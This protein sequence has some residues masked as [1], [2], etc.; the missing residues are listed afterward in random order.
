[1]VNEEILFVK[2]QPL[3]TIVIYAAVLQVLNCEIENDANVSENTGPP[4]V[5]SSSLDFLIP[6][7][8]LKI[9]YLA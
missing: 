7:H 9:P 8:Q 3:E 1:V 6:I 2:S 5:K 4:P